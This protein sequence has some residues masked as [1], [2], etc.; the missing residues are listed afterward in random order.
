MAAQQLI[1]LRYA[2]TATCAAAQLSFQ[3]RKIGAAGD[4]RI[5]L[6][7]ADIHAVAQGFGGFD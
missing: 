3:L 5:D 4:G 7:Q 1:N 2:R 6:L